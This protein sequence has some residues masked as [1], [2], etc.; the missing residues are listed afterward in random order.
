VL[1]LLAAKT[2]PVIMFGAAIS[3]LGLSSVY[4]IS[5]SLLSRWFGD[6]APRISGAIFA[7]GNFGGAV[8]PWVVG[9]LSTHLGSLRAGFAVP[10]VGA[11]SMLV[12]YSAQGKRVRLGRRE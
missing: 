7:C 4:P 12:F 9:A 6:A 11:L 3:G 8:L 2:L 10:L 1:I 5:V